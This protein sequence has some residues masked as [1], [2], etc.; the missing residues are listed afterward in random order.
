M[1][2]SPIGRYTMTKSNDFNDEQRIAI[3][4]R[5]GPYCC[6]SGAGTGKTKTLVGRFHALTKDI[7]LDKILCLTFTDSAAEEM[8][9][10]AGLAKTQRVFRT[11]HSFG[12][13]ILQTMLGV[14]SMPDPRAWR[15]LSFKL[16]RKYGIEKAKE[17]LGYI[18]RMKRNGVNP[19]DA[20]ENSESDIED[21]YA[22]AYRE[23]SRTQAEE[24]WI[25]FDDMLVL[26]KNILESDGDARQRFSKLA[27]QVDEAQDTDNL[28]W[29]IVQL[30]GSNVFFV[31][32]PNQAIYAWR[33]AHPE[34]MIEFTKWF[35]TGKYLYLGKNYRS[36]VT[37][38][39]YCRRK[40][41]IQNELTE[42]LHSASGK[43]GQPIEYKCY[44]DP[45]SEATAAIH[46]ALKDPANTAI[47]GRTNRLLATVE[48]ICSEHDIKYKLLGK[49]G[50][51]HQPEIKAI[52]AYAKFAVT[53]NDSSLKEVIR[54]PLSPTR[55]LKKT[56]VIKHLTAAKELHGDSTRL[57]DLLTSIPVEDGQR[58]GLHRLH[59]FLS[60]LS[61][62]TRNLSGAEAI[63]AVV[64]ATD[65]AN[66][67]G[68]DE[69]PENY[70]V[71]N[72]NALPKFAKKSERLSDFVAHATKCAHASRK[73][74]G[75]TL[76]TVH[77][78]KG[79]EWKTVILIGCCDGMLPH[80][81]GD[82]DEEARIFYVAI[83]RPAE[84]LRITWCGVP[85]PFI[86]DD[87]A[88][89]DPAKV[90][91]SQARL[92]RAQQAVQL[93]LLG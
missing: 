32:D 70:A 36:T 9:A 85:S 72:I 48:N 27:I 28:Q 64:A 53:G 10:R 24:H 86:A 49:S 56:E 55:Y 66:H 5:E 14:H 46:E 18:S 84:R 75:V 44:G 89:L 43:I 91:D 16:S 92:L 63:E 41:P 40:A 50:Y 21:A 20:I 73:K 61:H 65:A 69:D 6:L 1:G 67:Y 74:Q 57:F 83:S 81:K 62:R 15:K 54:S 22:R 11:F 60:E 93:P 42:L 78:A 4:S 31:G 80:K 34:N 76:S 29:R 87:I 12:F 33:G 38:V 77:Q 30:L 3:A 45:D 59:S 37:I 51:W 71:E 25:D 52:M 17:L 47:L 68:D 79:L 8:A 35:P 7:P 39:D 58:E 90:I 82:T 88:E 26:P 2:A 19:E 13:E 23:Y